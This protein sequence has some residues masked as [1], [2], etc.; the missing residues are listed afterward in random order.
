M[1]TFD[2]ARKNMVDCQIQTMGVVM[3]ELLAADERIPRERFVP[4]GLQHIACADRDLPLG[5]GRYL[6]D[7]STHARLLQAAEPRPTDHVLDIGGCTGYSA[8]ILSGLVEK[9]IALEENREFLEQ[10]QS[11]WRGL[12]LTNIIPRKGTLAAGDP[13]YAPYDL[14][15]VNGAMHSIPPALAA[16]LAPRGRMLA[17]L[18]QGENDIGHACRVSSAGQGQFSTYT[19][20]EAGAPF[21]PGLSP[22]AAFVF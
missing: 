10:G 20:F 6:L 8:A 7:S 4:A 16:Q 3:P 19:L 22:P 11:L 1:A 15:I 9:V 13:E 21:L 14:I 5:G 12:G 17:I 18:K 2:A